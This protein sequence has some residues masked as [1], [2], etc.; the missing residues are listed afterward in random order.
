MELLSI[1]ESKDLKQMRPNTWPRLD[2]SALC[3]LSLTAFKMSQHGD[4]W[5]TCEWAHMKE[6]WFILP[7]QTL[8]RDCYR[9]N[10]KSIEY[11]EY[12]VDLLIYDWLI[13]CIRW[14]LCDQNISWWNEKPFLLSSGVLKC[15][16]FLHRLTIL[17]S[18]T[19]PCPSL[20]NVKPCAG[21]QAFCWIRARKL[22]NTLLDEYS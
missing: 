17:V 9:C 4:P 5:W 11:K 21:E 20:F 8:Y 6:N 2:I 16:C 12:A 10:A 15:C 18:S 14:K 19:C 7:P 22:H 13:L 1:W 3:E